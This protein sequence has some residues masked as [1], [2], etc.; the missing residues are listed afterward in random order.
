[1][2]TMS[3]FGFAALP[4]MTKPFPP[5]NRGRGQS[6]RRDNLTTD[7]RLREHGRASGQ[8]FLPP[9]ALSDSAWSAVPVESEELRLDMG[10][11]TSGAPGRA[12]KGPFIANFA[13]KGPF[14]AH[15]R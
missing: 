15:V 7:D 11:V 3:E 1:M 12:M 9:A 8:A 6:S 10:G 13:M 2:T 5:G 4:V 14:I